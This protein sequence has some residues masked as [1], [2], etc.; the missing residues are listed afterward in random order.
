MAGG[1]GAAIGGFGGT[2]GGFI[3]AIGGFG[4]G[5]GGFGVTIGGFG[6]GT[7][8]IIWRIAATGFIKYVKIILK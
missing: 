1:F 3:A 5:T 4:G 6:G 7:A 2:A 8:G